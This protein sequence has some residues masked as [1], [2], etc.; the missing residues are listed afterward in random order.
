MHDRSHQDN[1]VIRSQAWLVSLGLGCS[2]KTETHGVDFISAQN[3]KNVVC[4]VNTCLNAT[5]LKA[6]GFPSFDSYSSG[7]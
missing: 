2:L 5:Q 3:L 4:Q 6:V 7:I 1:Q